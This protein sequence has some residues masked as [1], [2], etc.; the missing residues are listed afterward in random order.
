MAEKVQLHTR[1]SDDRFLRWPELKHRIGLSRSQ[2]HLM[3]SRG[4]FPAPYKLGSRSSAW[5]KSSIDQWI[6]SRVSA[7]DKEV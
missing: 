4:E 5:L 6:R 3:I 2:I 1:T 7:S